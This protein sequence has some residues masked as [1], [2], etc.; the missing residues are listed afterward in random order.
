MADPTYGFFP[1]GTEVSSGLKW[2]KEHPIAATAAAAAATAVS[3]VTYL[4]ASEPRLEHVVSWCDSH[5]N[6]ADKDELASQMQSLHVDDTATEESEAALA[7]EADEHKAAL[8]NASPQWGWYVAI[9]PPRD[10]MAAHNLPRAITD[11]QMRSVRPSSNPPPPSSLGNMRR[12][13]SVKML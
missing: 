2:L 10:P 9:T 7:A 13:V 4:R 12:T 6:E 1:S 11:P 8:H 5:V 3:I